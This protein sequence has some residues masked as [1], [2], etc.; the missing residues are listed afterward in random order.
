MTIRQPNNSYVILAGNGTQTAFSFP[1]ASDRFEDDDVFVYVWNGTSEQWDKKTV[2]THYT[3]GSNTVTFSTAP[4]APPTGVTGNVLVIR[5]TDVD[6]DFPRADFQ[7]GSS[8]R[9]QD[10]DNNQLQALRGLKELRDEKLSRFAEVDESNGTVSNPKMYANLD[11]TGRN[12]ENLGKAGSDDGAANREMVGDLIANDITGDTSQGVVLNKSV[13]GTNSGDQLEVSIADSSPSQKGSVIIEQ[14]AGE[15]VNVSY[16]SGTATIGVDKSTASQQGVV[17]IQQAAGESANVTYTAD[18]EVTV[19]VDKSTATQQGSVRIQQSDAVNVTY[20]ADG[21]VTVGVDRSTATQQGVVRIQ[22]TNPVTT[23]YTADG[24]V[25]LSIA[26]GSVDISKIKADD[27]RT[28]TEQ[29]ATPNATGSDDEIGTTAANDKR[30]DTIYQSGTPSGTDWPVGKIWYDHAN[31]QTLSVWSGSN[32]LG[33]SSGGTFVT[34]PTVIW[35]DQANGV[36]TNDGHRIIDAMKTI[37]AAVASADHGDIILV[38]PGV[39]REIAPIDITVNNLSIV[40]QSLRS[41]FVHPTPATEENTLFRVNSGTQIANFSICGLKASGTRGGHA[42]DSDSTYGLPTNQAFVAEFYPNSVIY[43]SP[44]IQNCTNFADSGIPNHTEAEYNADNSLGGFFD[45]NNVNQGGFGGDLTSGPTGGGLLVDGAAV[46]TSS[47]LRSMVVD[48]FTQITMDGPGILCCNNGY[49]QLVSFFGTF[50]HYHA[51]SLNGG[52]LN[53]SNCTTDYGRYGLIADGKSTTAIFTASATAAAST[54]DLF[55]TIGAQTAGAAWHGSA[56][57]PQDNMLVTIGSNTYPVKSATANGAG[58]DVYIENPDPAALAT[59]LGLA[60]GIAI[61]DAVSFF[62]RSYISTGGHTFEYVGSG[63]DYRADPANGGVPIE[64]NQVKSLNNGKVWQSSTDHNGKFKVGDTFSVNQRSGEVFI[65][66]DA[67]RPEL[68]NDLTPQLGGDLDVNNKDITGTVKLNGLT[69]PSS[70][71]ATNQVLKTD[72]AGNLSF[73]AVSQLTGGGLQDIS[74]DTTPQLGGNLDVLS[75][76]INTS[77]TNGNIKLNPNGTGVVEI[78]GDGSSND[79]TLQLNCSQNSHGVKLKSPAHSAGASYTMTLPT[80]MPS[81]TGQMLTSDTNGNLSFADP[82]P[83]NSITGAELNST[84]VTAGNYT[85]ADLTI[86]AQGRITAASNGVIGANELANT[87]VT[88]GTY[89][90]AEITVDAQGRLTAAANGSGGSSIDIVAT[91]TIPNGAS[92]VVRSD[93]TAEVVQQTTTV[94]LSSGSQ[95]T[96]ISSAANQGQWAVDNVNDRVYVAWYDNSGYPYVC[97]GS[98]NSS[99]GTVVFGSPT[100][101]QSY[102]VYTT[103]HIAVEYDPSADRVIVAYYGDPTYTHRMKLTTLSVNSSNLN[104]TVDTT[105]TVGYSASKAYAMRYHPVHQ[106][107]VIGY[108]DWGTGMAIRTAALSAGGIN[109]SSANIFDNNN[110]GNGAPELVYDSGEQRMVVISQIQNNST[111]A[112]VESSFNSFNGQMTLGTARTLPNANG[113]SNTISAAYDATAQKVVIVYNQYNAGHNEYRRVVVADVTGGTTNDITF[114]N[115]Q[116]IKD[117]P[118]AR[119]RFYSSAGSTESWSRV[120]YDPD[121]GQCFLVYN[122]ED[123]GTSGYTLRVAPL[124]ITSGTN[125]SI[126]TEHVVDSTVSFEKNVN[127]VY[128]TGPNKVALGGH[129]SAGSIRAYATSTTATGSN[130]GKFIGFSDAAYTNGQTATISLVGAVSENQSGLT[131]GEKYYVQSD[132]SLAT[133]NTDP[134]GSEYAGISISSTKLIVKA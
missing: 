130:V 55:F 113:Q 48:S 94:N 3:L 11:M 89:T 133:T 62:Y 60:A 17:K 104:M 101:V 102:G 85:A 106:R 56:T 91:G 90:N 123:N 25:E 81:S 82:V 53:L 114:G 38:A 125:F 32:W 126:G 117:N 24:E 13:G 8:I 47:P 42:I 63:T 110:Y 108:N 58:W 99:N 78:K 29:N 27:I 46:S 14:A 23:T 71:G 16:T 37:K 36:D 100:N 40:G 43:K 45:P 70:D 83:A 75:S 1:F 64:A 105:I 115:S 132:G 86:D 18:G 19:G 128:M 26:D 107:V 120:V 121:A 131:A 41:C 31:D 33:V 5:K 124:N 88:P 52:Q 61:G 54:G 67:Y 129:L 22:S 84:G 95:S 20:T 21:E 79:G 9:A 2:T 10:L 12:I 76:E 118:S 7:P 44:Y 97:A 103:Y 50:C 6:E 96:V 51:K 127:A 4:S 74:D 134:A 119:G 109:L 72:G 112:M 87:S 98:F 15:A 49:A 35:V 116:L 80:A 66:L 65:S 59:N 57:R 28:L 73:I 68:V 69:Y 34:Q 30:Y 122:Y 93:G 92:V 39:Y 111:K 77:T